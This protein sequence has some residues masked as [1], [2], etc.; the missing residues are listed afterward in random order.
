MFATNLALATIQQHDLAADGRI[1][2]TAVVLKQSCPAVI[3]S[4]P[5]IASDAHVAW[6]HDGH[7]SACLKQVYPSSAA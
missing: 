7:A 5:R 4:D 2:R 1:I 6:T 3:P